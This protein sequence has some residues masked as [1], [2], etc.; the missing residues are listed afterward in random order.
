MAAYNPD[1]RKKYSEIMGQE[2]TSSISEK[3]NK[4]VEISE[5]AE[6]NRKQ[7]EMSK[8]DDDYIN[9]FLDSSN[10]FFDTV[11]KDYESVGW[12]NASQIYQKHQGT[13]DYLNRQR[14]VIKDWTIANKDYLD[15][16]TYRYLSDILSSY[17]LGTSSAMKSLSEVKDYYD[18]D[19]NSEAY[20]EYVNYQTLVNYDL[21]AGQQKIDDLTRLL[22]LSSSDKKDSYSDP[23]ANRHAQREKRS[24]IDKYGLSNADDITLALGN[25]KNLYAEAEKVNEAENL[26]QYIQGFKSR[27]DFDEH[28]KYKSTA[29]GKERS[30]A[31]TGHL[32]ETG[33]DDLEY[34]YIN[35]NP[36]A[37]RVSTN[38]DVANNAAFLG[39]DSGEQQEMNED[40]IAVYNYLYATEGPEAAKEFISKITSDL[41]Y[42]ERKRREEEARL[43][44]EQNPFKESVWSIMTSPLKSIS[45]I[46]QIAAATTG[47]IDQN[48]SYN[49][50]V[51]ES[52]AVRSAISDKILESGKWG[53]VGSFLYNT[54]MSMGDFLMQTAISGGNKYVAM[55]VMG[56]GAAADTVVS[57]MD[58]GLSSNQAFA[59]GTIAGLAE[60]VTEK[61]SLEALLDAD[62][63]VDSAWKYVLKNMLAEGSEEAASGVINLF[64]DIII[65]R[66]KSEWYQSILKIMNERNVT[67]EEAFGIAF[68]DQAKNI[69]LEALSGALSGGAMGGGGVVVNSAMNI[70]TK[71][72]LGS[73]Q[74][75][76][77]KS[78]LELDPN[79]QFALKMQSR[80]NAGKN[81][82]GT[83][84]NG[85]EQVTKS[86]RYAQYM[87]DI[88][89]S[90]KSALAKYGETNNIQVV[91]KAIA[92][93]IL[94]DELT[95]SE[96]RALSKSQYGQRVA[97]ELNTDM[98]KA[99]EY[100]S[101]IQKALSESDGDIDIA[102]EHSDLFGDPESET[103]SEPATVDV[104]DPGAVDF[105]ESYRALFDDA[106]AD[107]AE[108]N[109]PVETTADTAASDVD[110]LP[111]GEISDADSTISE[112]AQE[113]SPAPDTSVS[114]EQA[115]RKYGAQAKAM[116]A[117][118]NQGQ[119]VAK[120]DR[121]YRIAYDMGKASPHMM[122]YALNSEA[123]SYLTPEQIRHAVN[124]GMA[125]TDAR[126]S[127][128]ERENKAK[129]KVTTRRKEGTV[130][131]EGEASEFR[132]ALKDPKDPRR[133]AIKTLMAIAKATGVNIV[134]T[135]SK[136]D[137]KGRFVGDQGQY[138]WS[139]DT[140]FIDI[141]SGLKY[142]SDIGEISKYAMLRTFGHEFTHFLEKN[143]PKQ[144]SEFRDFVFS[145][146]TARGENVDHLIRKKQTEYEN[147]SYEAASREVVAE[148]MTDILRDSKYIAQLEQQNMGL[149]QKLLSKLKEFV[150]SIKSQFE[151]MS[152]NPSLEAKALQDEI[153]DTMKYLDSIIEK[154]DKLA[155]DAVANYQGIRRNSLRIDK[156]HSTHILHM[157]LLRGCLVILRLCSA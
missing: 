16:E 39:L 3:R 143:S 90:A 89:N 57:A 80:L 65:S 139:D 81:L 43:R 8:V 94:G 10:R 64:A 15:S 152:E 121:G 111:T 72:K 51:Y 119:D 127:A 102:K 151:A 144:Y 4:Y 118:Y 149:F 24:L 23:S 142:E 85:L 78:A 1:K 6:Q 11:S 93:Q 59:L 25:E 63:L 53:G 70:G 154:F 123:T 77:V 116:M 32:K 87:D 106:E 33:F 69:G 155:A 92:K 62:A 7:T 150:A 99:Q 27:P 37:I 120:F 148:S 88:T 128:I 140:I 38:N 97:S 60:A 157:S 109:A 34:D 113:S 30:Y 114:L 66:D 75:A 107:L 137:S 110:P 147:I 131:V 28:S 115:S 67:R 12:D 71:S 68:A 100:I 122:R 52:A 20:T 129:G 91:S 14:D 55:T 103:M 61:F 46:G 98:I 21:D 42:R 101:L 96:Q 5:R 44:A 54:G 47:G 126:D 135:M 40:E 112:V 29:N 133:N 9:D 73:Q 22:E 108:A 76:L 45:Y 58:R 104:V 145:M 141:N 117:T 83:Q 124:A 17:Y 146:M 31:L 156:R 35:K 132:E 138:R 153:G 79:N 130:K 41:N 136:V 49:K 82:S 95:W 56:S 2:D 18:K 84:L 36:D 74:D 86:I 19:K 125:A 134:L 26:A 50:Y 105:E 13:I 48:A